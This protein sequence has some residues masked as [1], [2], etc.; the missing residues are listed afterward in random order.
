MH[1]KD[2]FCIIMRNVVE[3]GHTAAEIS[4]FLRFLV[5]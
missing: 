1:L 4:Q 3:I 2:M 5:M